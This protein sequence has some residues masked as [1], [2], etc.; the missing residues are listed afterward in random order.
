MGRTSTQ[1]NYIP[2][3]GQIQPVQP[4]PIAPLGNYGKL[5]SP[6][7]AEILHFPRGKWAKSAEKGCAFSGEKSGENL[8][9]KTLD[10]RVIRWALQ[11]AAREI[12]PASGL[13]YCLRALIPDK[14][15]VEVWR[16]DETGKAHFK[17]LCTCGS[18]WTCAPCSNKISEA[19]R[20]ELKAAMERAE[21]YTFYMV[22]FTL[23]HGRKDKLDSLV[24]D[25][26]ASYRRMTS[27]KAYQGFI[28]RCGVVGNIKALEVTYSDR[29][30]FHPHLHIL[31]VTKRGSKVER[32]WLKD[33]WQ[34]VIAA[35]DRTADYSIGC[36]FRAADM[37][38]AEYVEKYG[39]ERIKDQWGASG[40]ITSGAK[41]MTRSAHGFSMFQVLYNSITAPDE[42]ER[43]RWQNIFREYA[44]AFKG[45]AQLRYSAG[46]RDLLGMNV[47]KTDQ[48]LAAGDENPSSLLA[49]LSVRQWRIVLGNDAR[50]DLLKAAEGG[51]QVF[52]DFIREIGAARL[53]EDDLQR[54]RAN[55]L[56]TAN[57]T[58][59]SKSS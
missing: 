56:R 14:E 34:R 36:H 58:R 40:E 50:G 27:G 55:V 4:V 39:H 10:F 20:T 16:H 1:Q 9:G 2:N 23:S 13:K 44:A 11:A 31:M 33:K 28:E 26:L 15:S 57:T 37:S 52:E 6:Y 25:L 24:S 49:T 21:K 43:A 53:P 47:E 29:N 42:K 22:T 41:K 54:R 3:L 38:A 35:N 51:L 12:L 32:K 19:R 7:N 8:G 30:G 18:V 48:E 45:R 17:G 5:A 46:L 59:Q